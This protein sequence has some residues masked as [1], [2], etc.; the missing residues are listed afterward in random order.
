MKIFYSSP[1]VPAEWIKA[2]GFEPHGIWSAAADPTIT[3]P[4]GVCA[5]AQQ[6][7][8]FLKTF[9]H[10]ALILTTACD[11]MRRAADIADR[12]Q[13]RVFLFNLPATWQTPSVQQLYLSEIERLG[14][15]LVKLGGRAPPPEELETVMLEWDRRRQTLRDLLPRV[16]PRQA[17][18]LL[19]KFFDDGTVPALLPPTPSRG[20]PLAL[21]GGPILQ[22][23]L[24]LLDRLES[25]GGGVVLNATEPG[26]RCLL[27]PLPPRLPGQRPIVVLANHYFA[28]S[29]D[30]FHR[31]NSR[32]YNWLAT[33]LD[34]R[35]VRGIILSAHVG[36]DLWRAEAASLR[37]A[38]GL[39]VLLLDEHEIRNVG[40]R[41]LTRLGAFVE[42]LR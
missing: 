13:A 19:M 2:H 28:H 20:V 35:H 7:P 42:S 31:P 17:A 26:E 25:V 23:Q 18:E 27:P 3:K 1:W 32:L 22:S 11:Q 38:F 39:P 33:R 36:C 5:F 12:S 37:E 30:V 15:F 24:D 40:P 4:E 29:I 21:I 8:A 16:R 14:R 41:D 9:P 6:F 34:E 10:T